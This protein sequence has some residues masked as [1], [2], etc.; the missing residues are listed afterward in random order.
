MTTELSESLS[1]SYQYYVKCSSRMG[2]EITAIVSIQFNSETF[3]VQS[4]TAPRF[5]R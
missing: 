2:G 4:L 3:K 1:Q 5:S